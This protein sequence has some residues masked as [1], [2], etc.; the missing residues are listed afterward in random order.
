MER[1]SKASEHT[2]T[3]LILGQHMYIQVYCTCMHAVYMYKRVLLYHK[4][5][6]G[7]DTVGGTVFLS[8]CMHCTIASTRPLPV[9]MSSN[10][11]PAWCFINVHRRL[12]RQKVPYRVVL[13]S[14]YPMRS[15]PYPPKY[16]VCL[17]MCTHMHMKHQWY[18]FIHVYTHIIMLQS[19]T[20]QWSCCHC[21]LYAHVWHNFIAWLPISVCMYSVGSIH[22]AFTYL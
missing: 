18:W 8:H 17:S 13:P 1:H 7:C 19:C 2:K 9:Y 11:L 10:P 21:A 16:T 20:Y 14:Q 4:C 15:I 3:H 6:R 5:V 22:V 12:D